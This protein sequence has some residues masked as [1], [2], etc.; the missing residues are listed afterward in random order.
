MFSIERSIF[1]KKR[2]KSQWNKNHRG[3]NQAVL[4]TLAVVRL[5]KSS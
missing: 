2:V 1:T 5:A 4:L 3:V